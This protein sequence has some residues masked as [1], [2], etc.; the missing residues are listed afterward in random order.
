MSR[1]RVVYLIDFACYKP[2]ENL[3]LSRQ[4]FM[5]HIRSIGKFNEA[6]LEFQGKAMERSGMGEETYLP[7]AVLANPPIATMKEARGEA[8]MVMF[9]T[10]DE[11]F[12]KT[13]VRPKDVGVLVVNCGLF[14]PTPSL[15]AMV[16]NHYTM[17][18][19]ILSFNIGGMGCS[20]GVIALDLAN[21]MLQASGSTYAVVIGSQVQDCL[22]EE[23]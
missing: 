6:S 7:P 3:K 21:D 11:L 5:D 1:P 23:S 8:E 15:S 16:I 17:R 13:K 10:I 20:A 19:N 22:L 9:S 4:A 14:N 2:P 12:E 18:G